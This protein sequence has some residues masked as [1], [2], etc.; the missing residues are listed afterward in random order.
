[1]MVD[2]SGVKADKSGPAAKAE[3]VATVAA[4]ATINFEIVN[5]LSPLKKIEQNRSVSRSSEML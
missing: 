5:I 3:E 4:T 2:V 1:M